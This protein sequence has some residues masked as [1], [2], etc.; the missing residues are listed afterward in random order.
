[1]KNKL[2]EMKNLVKDSEEYKSSIT[3]ERS[4][5]H[6]SRKIF[7]TWNIP[8]YTI[9]KVLQNNET[10]Q[11]HVSAHKSRGSISRIMHK[12]IPRFNKF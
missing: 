3:Q 1:M 9:C 7:Q 10:A 6:K 12:F 8:I 2:N 4:I 5:A 11:K